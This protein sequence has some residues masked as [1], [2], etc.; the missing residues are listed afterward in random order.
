MSICMHW[1]SL[2]HAQANGQIE[3]AHQML[4]QMIGKL[5]KDQKVNWPKHLIEMVH[6]YN[7]TRSA[8][9]GYS[10]HYLMFGHRPCLPINFYFPTIRSTEK[11]QCDDHYIADLHKWLWEAFKEVQAQSTSETERQKQY[12]DQKVNAVSLEPADLVL[13]KANASKGWRKVK[14]WWEKEPYEVEHSVAEG[15]PSYLIKNRQTRHSWVLHRNWLFPIT[16]ITGIPFCMGV[17]AE[18]SKCTTNILEEQTL[19]ENETGEVP[20][21]VNCHQTGETPLGCVNRK[22]CAFLRMFS[23]GSLLDQGWTVCADVKLAF[24]GQRYW[25]HRW[26]WKTWQTTTPPLFILEIVSL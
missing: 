3:K 14:D 1:P 4:M 7:S 13:A 10:P 26:S 24:W 21:I 25:S 9:T 8:I 17:Q 12:Y 2:F 6:A 18:Q 20:Q 16:L 19:K 15:V 5:S 22:L 23:R 11:H